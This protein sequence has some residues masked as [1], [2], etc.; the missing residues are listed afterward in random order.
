MRS[1]PAKGEW[2]ALPVGP[3]VVAGLAGLAG[4]LPLEVVVRCSSGGGGRLPALLVTLRGRLVLCSRQG[5]FGVELTGHAT[6]DFAW[7]ALRRGRGGPDYWQGALEQR[8]EG[9]P[10]VV[11]YFAAALNEV[12]VRYRRLRG[13]GR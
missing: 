6:G 7:M 10:A 8:R 2:I 4:E 5:R 12:E 3:E 1:V 9:Y 11:V 13:T